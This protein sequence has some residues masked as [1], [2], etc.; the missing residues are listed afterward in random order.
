MAATYTI[1][2]LHSG[3]ENN[4]R[5]NIAA[6]MRGLE[7][8]KGYDADGKKVSINVLWA[9]DTLTNLTNYAKQLVTSKVNVI[10]AAGG[11]ASAQAAKAATS[12]IPIVF[13]SVTDPNASGLVVD[14]M[15]G[16]C[17]LT[18][19]LDPM[20]LELL[21]NYFSGAGTIVPLINGS[22][23]GI[24]LQMAALAVKAAKLKVKLSNSYDI[25]V[26]AGAGKWTY[27]MTQIDLAFTQKAPVLVT[28]DRLFHNNRDRVLRA[29]SANNVPAI[30]QWREFAVAG[31][32]MSYGPN[33]I[34]I[35]R[36]AGNFVR[37]ILDGAAPTDLPV[38][39]PSSF[40][41]VI[42]R[43]TNGLLPS[44]IN[45]SSMGWVSNLFATSTTLIN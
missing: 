45:T 42:N 19:E 41:L 3:T 34:D 16:V 15:T 20:R 44:P 27:D 24:Q 35:Y 9:E 39:T 17:A 5:E 7:E 6:L 26:S 10:V 12:T 38:S 23:S 1:G 13:T 30:Y 37:N 43:G 40:E 33:I 32:L 18:S 28:A 8:N 25:A 31:G 21:N 2:I 11:T 22:R 14:N 4:H 36:K 29:E